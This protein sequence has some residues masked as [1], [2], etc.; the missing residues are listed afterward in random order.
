MRFQISHDN[1]FELFRKTIPLLSNQCTVYLQAL[2]WRVVVV[3]DS[4]SIHIHR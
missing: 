2:H 4:L 1:K 3:E